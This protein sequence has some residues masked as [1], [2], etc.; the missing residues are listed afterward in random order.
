MSDEFLYV[1]KS[2]WDLMKRMAFR[3]IF[4]LALSAIGFWAL[5]QMVQSGIND[6]YSLVQKFPEFLAL[7]KAAA[8]FTFIEMSL[9]WIRMAT[10]PK[11]DVQEAVCEALK[12]PMAAAVVHFTNSLVWAIRIAVFLWLAGPLS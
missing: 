10:Q 11:N 6:R 4:L 12:E 7:M 5:E 1:K 8:C 2:S 3:S 9:F